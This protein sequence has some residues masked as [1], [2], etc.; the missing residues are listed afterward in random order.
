L[1][2]SNNI[3]VIYHILLWGCITLSE[4]FLTK[5][6]GEVIAIKVKQ[7]VIVKTAYKYKI[8]PFE[9]GMG[10][11]NFNLILTKDRFN[12]RRL[13][14]VNQ[15]GVWID[16]GIYKKF[17]KVEGNKKVEDCKKYEVPVFIKWSNI[18]N[19]FIMNNIEVKED[20]RYF[21]NPEYI[22]NVYVHITTE[23]DTMVPIEKREINFKEHKQ[24]SFLKPIEY[25]GKKYILET[26][27]ENHLECPEQLTQIYKF[28]PIKQKK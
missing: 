6:I 13:L 7:E 5:Y 1:I 23:D 2:I 9:E 28:K 11:K 26:E 17:Y 21:V 25:R 14:D 20:E 18:E 19:I 8:N 4:L 3:Y 16:I 15:I 12:Y 22:E 24:W 27:T 10:F